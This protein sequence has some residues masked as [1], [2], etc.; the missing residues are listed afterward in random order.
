MKRFLKLLPFIILLNACDDGN[1]NLTSFNFGNTEIQSCNDN[2]NVLYK[3]N[4]NEV[5][6]L[7]I[8]SN[9]FKNE[10]GK[11]TITIGTDNVST[12]YRLYSSTI[13]SNNIC[14]A[15]PLGN[16]IVTDEQIAE[17]GG[18]IEIITSA[19]FSDPDPITNLTTITNYT[20]TILFQNITFQ[21]GTGQTIFNNY[22]FG[23]HTTKAPAFDFENQ[24]MQTCNNNL[25]YRRN[26]SEALL[27]YLPPTVFPNEVKT[28]T[29][30]I[31]ASN[32]LVY[33]QY[34]NSSLTN[35][36]I[37]AVI[38]PLSPT[39]TFESVA[40]NG[41]L[42]SGIIIETSPLDNNTGFKHKITLKNITFNSTGISPY[43]LEFGTY[44]R[45][46]P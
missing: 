22:R 34:N 31:N 40:T 20:H 32:R 27:L 37:C 23:V 39:V 28:D 42:Q 1:F 3:I 16:P 35:D 38:P 19:V 13:T 36:F 8:P 5:L 41:A 25:F 11:T 14:N 46:T 44:Q 33:R 12:T 30:M 17:T 18:K 15:I 24:T 9:N 6:I 2:N 43:N 45:L 7:Y 10:I 21:S 26:A 4:E 29:I